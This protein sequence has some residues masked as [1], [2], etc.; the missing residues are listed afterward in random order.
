[1][2]KEYLC[3]HCGCVAFKNYCPYCG[4]EWTTREYNKWFKNAFDEERV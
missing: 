1:M 3:I 2:A 4:E